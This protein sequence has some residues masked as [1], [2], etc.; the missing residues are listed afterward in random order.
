MFQS[1]SVFMLW[2]KYSKLQTVPLLP[3]TFYYQPDNALP[4]EPKGLN[5]VNAGNVHWFTWKPFTALILY[6]EE[7]EGGDCCA[8]IGR[9]ITICGIPA[10]C[11]GRSHASTLFCDYFSCCR[12]QAYIE[13]H[14][15]F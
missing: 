15:L 13:F 2:R 3:P 14:E 6:K 5:V 9:S 4:L 1:S 10:A 12:S 7:G 11:N 8:N